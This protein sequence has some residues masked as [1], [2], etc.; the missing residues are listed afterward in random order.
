M[1]GDIL[2]DNLLTLSEKLVLAYIKSWWRNKDQC[3]SS[4]NE[5]ANYLNID[6]YSVIKAIK[7]LKAYGYISVRYLKSDIKDYKGNELRVLEAPKI[8]QAEQLSL[9]FKNAVYGR[10]E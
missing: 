5:I 7:K 8:G 1:E 4:N 2:S 3:I 10:K 9:L 6:R